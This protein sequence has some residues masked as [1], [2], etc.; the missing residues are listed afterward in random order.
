MTKFKKGQDV[1]IRP[2]FVDDTYENS[3]LWHEG[4][5]IG[6]VIGPVECDDI[7]QWYEVHYFTKGTGGITGTRPESQLRTFMLEDDV[8]TLVSL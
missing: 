4:T 7:E 8:D 5:I 3:S 1:L 2:A 6:P